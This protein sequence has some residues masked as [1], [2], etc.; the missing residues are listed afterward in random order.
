MPTTES[1][2]IASPSAL[3]SAITSPLRS[4]DTSK[5][6]S[7]VKSLREYISANRVEISETHTEKGLM[8]LIDVLKVRLILQ[9]LQYTFLPMVYIV[10]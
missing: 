3:A 7:K 5:S 2:I 6:R 8:E 10:S 9:D 4:A 1:S